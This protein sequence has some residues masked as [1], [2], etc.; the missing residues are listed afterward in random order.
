M[1][2]LQIDNFRVSDAILLGGANSGQTSKKC[3]D[4]A[5]Y[6]EPHATIKN[7]RDF[8]MMLNVKHHFQTSSSSGANFYIYELPEDLRMTEIL[9][10]EQTREDIFWIFTD[11]YGVMWVQSPTSSPSSAH[12]EISS[13]LLLTLKLSI[14]PGNSMY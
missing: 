6:V 12:I 4:L 10:H 11:F 2:L 3:C 1:L 13:M 7:C 5:C 14:T 8:I 9:A